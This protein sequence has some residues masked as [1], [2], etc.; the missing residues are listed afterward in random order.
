M[1]RTNT[2][3]WMEKQNRWQIK[4]QKNG[5][6]KTF[7]SSTKGRTGQ[8]EAN[9]KADAWLD[10]GIEDHTMKVCKAADEYLEQLKLTASTSHYKQTE[11]IMRMYIKARIGNV[12]LSDLHEQHLQSVI[13]YGYSRKLSKKTLKDIRGGITAFLRYCRKCHY[14]TLTTDDLVIPNGAPTKEKA[15]LQPSAL[16]TLFTVDTTSAGHEE[17][18]INAFRFQC[19]TGLRPGETVALKWNDIFKNTVHVQRSIN[20]HGETTTGKNDNARRSFDLNEL[21]KAILDNQ[22]HNGD[23]VF[24]ID[25]QPVSQRRYRER[26]KAYCKAN[27]IPEDVTPYGLRHTFVSVVKSLP[28][29]YLKALVGHS[30]DMDTYGIYSHSLTG[31]QAKTAEL[32]NEIFK[33]IL[34]A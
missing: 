15:I 30:E 34:G 2:A 20:V 16:K 22:E 31:D 28:E 32:V 25:G 4:V 12:R 14:T 3:V 24:G 27:D 11:Y 23:Y 33:G 7:Y 21:S 17:L 5:I 18:L 8:R 13:D 6:R 9:A 26:W 29:G 19:V 10:E 1:K